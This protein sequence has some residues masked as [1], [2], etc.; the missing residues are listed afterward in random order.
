M[1]GVVRE[2]LTKIRRHT[3]E[4][5]RIA[6]CYEQNPRRIYLPRHLEHL[7]TRELLSMPELGEVL[8]VDTIGPAVPHLWCRQ[9]KVATVKH[10]RQ[11]CVRFDN[12]E[13]TVLAWLP[14]GFPILNAARDLQYSEALCVLQR[15]AMHLKKARYRCVIAPMSRGD[16]HDR[17]GRGSRMEG[18]SVF[19][20]LGL[21]E[22]DGTPI[23]VVTHQF[24]HYLNTLAQAGGMSQLDIAKW[25]GRKD[26][27]Q[28]AAYDHVSDRDVAAQLRD[29]VGVEHRM[30]GPLATLHRTTLIPRDEFARLKIPTAHTT[31]VGFCVHDYTMSPCALHRDCLH[32]EE[33]ICIKGDAVKTAAIRRQHE[34]T[35]A[36]LVQAQAA[37]AQQCAGASR[38]VEHQ[39]ETLERLD[40]LCKILDD[41]QIPDGTFIQ[42]STRK[43]T[44]RSLPAPS[45][46]ITD[47]RD[48]KHVPV[49]SSDGTGDGTRT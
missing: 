34:E 28:N 19:D 31:E 37:T 27:R 33:L 42:L 29:A 21:Y 3:E 17:L 10:D 5:R 18:R 25:S 39:Q 6:R 24:R 22:Q 14:R 47:A 15:N 1:A 30:V 11:T 41:P 20:R 49:A 48:A 44:T 32:C 46:T 40:Q 8:F 13:K 16:V 12:V 9:H 36:L 35:Q 23:R 26:L 38:W 2:A 45:L 7:R 43:R 4:A